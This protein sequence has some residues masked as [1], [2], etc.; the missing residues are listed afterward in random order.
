M[1]CVNHFAFVTNG[2]RVVIGI[3]PP[4][5]GINPLQTF[6]ITIN[7]IK[8]PPTTK[9]SGRFEVNITDPNLSILS[10]LNVGSGTVPVRIMTNTPYTL[11]KATF[12]ANT[13]GAG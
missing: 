12:S 10:V 11:T 4:L 7:S 5:T 13:T 3:R 2:V 1:S 6:K 8:N 9:P